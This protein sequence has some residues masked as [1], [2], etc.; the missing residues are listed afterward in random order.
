MEKWMKINMKKIWKNKNILRK[1]KKRK[2]GNSKTRWN[3][4][5]VFFND[6][7]TPFLKM[8][9]TLAR[10]KEMAQPIRHKTSVWPV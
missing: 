7:L 4:F 8:W 5:D 2:N 9:V 1:R 3:N 6:S 10:M